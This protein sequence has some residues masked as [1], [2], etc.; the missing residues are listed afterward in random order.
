MLTGPV[1]RST[2]GNLFLIAEGA[3]SWLR[4]NQSTVALSTVE[5]EYMSSS[6]ASEEAVW[7]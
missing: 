6:S 7:L 3:V 1:T 4:K 2:S 5:A